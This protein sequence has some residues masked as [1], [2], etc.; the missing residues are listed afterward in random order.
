[1]SHNLQ[2]QNTVMTAARQTMAAW[3]KLIES[4]EEIPAVYKTHFD[5][6][7]QGGG[8]FPLVI[9]TP[10]LDRFPRKT[11]EKLI[12]DTDDAL[13]VFEKNGG[14]VDLTCYAYRE[15]FS[16]EMGIILLESWLIIRGKTDKGQPT[17]STI[18]INTTSK[19]YFEP[20]L[21]KLRPAFESMDKLQFAAEKEKFNRLSTVD[22][23]FMN[24][25]RESLVPGETVVRFLLQS[26]IRQPLFTIFGKTFDK[27]LAFAHIAILTDQELI[28]IEDAGS[29]RESRAKSY[30]GIWQYIPLRT[31]DSVSL[32]EITNGR[33]TLS[34]QC[35]PERRLPIL[36]DA[37]NLPELEQFRTDLQAWIGRSR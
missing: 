8:P 11:T 22:F 12:C 9:W 34:I 28:L 17:V 19:R 20:I 36:F 10:A 16:L 37:S 13:Y 6:T 30:G 1:M 14:Q 2:S 27:T 7:F 21:N 3:S 23:K 33:V 25:G 15:V 35:R 31:I 4:R 29:G 18:E 32:S 5:K 24:Y 26:E